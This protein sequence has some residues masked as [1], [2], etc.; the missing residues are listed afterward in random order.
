MITHE[1]VKTQPTKL[2]KFIESQLIDLVRK[3]KREDYHFLSF[4]EEV[5]E[6]YFNIRFDNLLIVVKMKSICR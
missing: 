6:E 1:L 2:V 5:S 3:P 4:G